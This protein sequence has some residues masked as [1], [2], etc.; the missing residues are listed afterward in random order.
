MAVWH[1]TYCTGLE[2]FVVFGVPTVVSTVALRDILCIYRGMQE[3]RT[4]RYYRIIV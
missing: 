4:I 3:F 1:N 2:G